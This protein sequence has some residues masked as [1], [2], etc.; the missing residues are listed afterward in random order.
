MNAKRTLTAYGVRVALWEMM[1]GDVTKPNEDRRWFE[2][3]LI[4][5]MAA[6]GATSRQVVNALIAYLDHG[7]LSVALDQHPS[8]KHEPSYRIVPVTAPQ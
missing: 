8:G 3:D 2:S 7:D 4:V 1:A 5:R 6:K